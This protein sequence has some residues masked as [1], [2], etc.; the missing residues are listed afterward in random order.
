M[1]PERVT[2]HRRIIIL[3]DVH[4]CIDEFNQILRLCSYKAESDILVSVGDLVNKGPSSVSVLDRVQRYGALVVRGNHEEAALAAWREVRRG[5]PP[6]KMKY[7]WV[8][9]LDDG[10]VSTLN[11]LPFTLRLPSYNVTVVHAGLVPGIAVED[12]NP[13]DLL[14]MRDV[15]PVREC[16]AA[17]YDEDGNGESNEDSESEGDG[18]PAVVKDEN[19]AVFRFRGSKRH[20]PNG[21]SWS[22]VWTGFPDGGHVFFG[23]DA[24]RGLQEQPWAT[25]LDGGC[26]YG[27]RLYAALLPPLDVDGNPLT[28][29]DIPS[30][31]TELV[32]GTGLPAWLVSIPAG[33]VYSVPKRKPPINVTESGSSQES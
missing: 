31:A 22:S 30:S 13:K 14:L 6:P 15:V 2:R 16:G 19:T 10:L 18:V 20:H 28:C 21:R 11:A 1:L 26:V 24:A 8:K 27:G 29:P 9:D 33:K 12:Q 17:T 4:G 32:L 3:G 25:G 5:L 23:H 7:A